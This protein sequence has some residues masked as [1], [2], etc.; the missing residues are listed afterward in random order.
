MKA[1]A[2]TLWVDQGTADCIE[3]LR[4]AGAHRAYMTSVFAKM[5][6]N[7]GL[8]KYETDG[9]YHTP[10]MEAQRTEPKV[11]AYP[12]VTLQNQPGDLQYEIDSFLHEMGYV[13]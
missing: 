2:I 4:V 11:I 7:I 12:G 6:F 8:D 3:R 10:P 1:K 9:G 5:V 13:E